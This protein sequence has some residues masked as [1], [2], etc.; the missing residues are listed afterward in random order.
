MP[1]SAQLS[2]EALGRRGIAEGFRG[3]KVA[4]RPGWCD[5]VIPSGHSSPWK[6]RHWQMISIPMKHDKIRQNSRTMFEITRG[7]TFLNATPSP[8][9]CHKESASPNWR[10][11]AN[12]G[13]APVIYSKP[14]HLDK[15]ITTAYYHYVSGILFCL[16]L[17]GGGV[18]WFCSG[19][20]I[21][22]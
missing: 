9:F 15:H 18:L 12:M 10:F 19:T 8:I 16:F 2:A 22:W 13:I 5:T 20:F 21:T 6:T 17:G 7:Y 11:I 14:Q 4:R 1:C 3:A